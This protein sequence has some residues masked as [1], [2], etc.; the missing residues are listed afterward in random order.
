[1]QKLKNY[2]KENPKKH[3]IF[4]YDD[5]LYHL[6]LPWAEYKEKI[7]ELMIEYDK[8]LVDK[9]DDIWEGGLVNQVIAK[10][11]KEV[12]DK[13]MG[14]SN[15]FEVSRLKSLSVHQE[16]VDFIKE[17]KNKYTFH[18]WT[19][20]MAASIHPLLE[21]TEIKD[22][23]DKIVTKTDVDLI[24]DS[25]DGFFKIFDPENYSRNDYLMVGNSAHDEGAAWNARIDFFHVDAGKVEWEIVEI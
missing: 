8:K 15:E 13:V 5:T 2:L 19:T 7:H 10:H 14:I 12:R 25:P 22:L 3:L 17:N 1:M 16:L 6:E 9:Y 21:K 23:F 24:K 4:D 18:L 20:N 11:G